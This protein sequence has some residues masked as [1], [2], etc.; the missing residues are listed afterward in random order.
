MVRYRGKGVP[1]RGGNKVPF[2]SSFNIKPGQRFAI[3][4]GKATKISK[5]KR[6]YILDQNDK[7]NKINY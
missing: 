5:G 4:G 6:A 1:E 7:L 3:V 2:E